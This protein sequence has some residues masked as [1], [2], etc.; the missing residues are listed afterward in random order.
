[1]NPRWWLLVLA[2]CGC[3]RHDEVA[4]S[5]TA[6]V[7]RY[8]LIGKQGTQS[9]D[10]KRLLPGFGVVVVDQHRVGNVWMA[11][12][13]L[14]RELPMSDLR[15]A[16]PSR[17]AGVHLDDKAKL[18]FGWVVKDGAPVYA[19]PEAGAKVIGRRPH[20]ARLSLQSLSGPQGFYRVGD[21]WMTEADLRVPH[22]APRP[23]GVADDEA[24]LDVELATQ[25][26]VAYVGERPVFATLVATGVG[27]EGTPFATPKGLHRIRGKLLAATMDNLEHTGVVPY[28]YEEVPFTQYIGRVALHGA[29]WH[30]QFGSPRSHGCINLSVSDAEWLFG[31]TKPALADG[32]TQAAA[33]DRKPATVVRVR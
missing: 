9:S 29:F 7:P 6:A 8:Y 12:T 2:A 11:R 16:K 28:S 10:G 26:L 31:F 15:L 14:G 32:D 23:G 24:W 33:T 25:T 20:Y 17:F 13:S 27:A 19:Q 4:T 21:G 30:D 5:T 1:M 18:D 3:G 22:R